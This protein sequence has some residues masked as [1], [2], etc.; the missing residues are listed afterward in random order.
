M[1]PLR[2]HFLELTQP[3]P[4]KLTFLTFLAVFEL[5]SLLCGVAQSSEMLIVGRAVAGLGAS[6]LTNGALTILAAALPMHKRPRKFLLVF[7]PACNTA[8]NLLIFSA[9]MAIIMGG[10]FTPRSIFKKTNT[11]CCG[12]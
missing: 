3:F 11:R 8:A 4:P 6:G 2:V 10:M 7:I 1:N 5:G 9:I 12:S